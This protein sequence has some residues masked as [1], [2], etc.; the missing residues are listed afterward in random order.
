MDKQEF[1][2]K[3]RQSKSR[4][5]ARM[6][7]P[8]GEILI[9]EKEFGPNKEFPNGGFSHRWAVFRDQGDMMKELIYDKY[10]DMHLPL[11]DRARAR[12][13]ATMQDALSWVA[14]NVDSGR[15]DQ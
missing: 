9:A 3:C 7:T 10:H 15:Y 4:P 12:E 11:V 5:I 14:L 8:A 2:E 6:N 13:N 1:E